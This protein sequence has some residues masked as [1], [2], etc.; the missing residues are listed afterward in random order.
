MKIFKGRRENYFKKSMRDELSAC[1]G[2][3]ECSIL[4][5]PFA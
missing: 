5:L 3:K 1:R 4:E 2:G